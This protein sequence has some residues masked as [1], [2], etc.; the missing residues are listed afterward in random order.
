[1]HFAVSFDLQNQIKNSSR[2]LSDSY[3][4]LSP[5]V[6]DKYRLEYPALNQ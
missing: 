6:L 2:I 5:H 1:M 3:T 4:K